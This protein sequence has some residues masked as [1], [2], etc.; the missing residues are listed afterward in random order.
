M[1]KLPPDQLKDP[2]AAVYAA[3]LCDDDTQVARADEYIKSAK[4]GRI[5]PEEKRLLEEIATRRQNPTP[6]PS[7]NESP[8]PPSPAPR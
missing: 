1:K 7:P 5:F 8:V 3:L 4:A 2:H 6:A